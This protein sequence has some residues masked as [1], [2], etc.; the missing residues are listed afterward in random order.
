MDT[1]ARFA[2]P[3]F[4]I[5]CQRC[6]EPLSSQQWS[7][8][9]TCGGTLRLDVDLEPARV[10]CR[11]EP[12]GRLNRFAP[13]LPL[14][15]A[16]DTA[17]GDT[18]L[19]VEEF[20][21]VRCAMKL[22]YLNP[23]GSFKD[24][25]A[26]V[27]AARC[28]ELGFD[29]IVVDS[30]GNAGV[31]MALMGL[32]LHVA[33]DVFLPRATPEGKKQLLR[34]LQARLHEVDGDRMQVQ[35]ETLAY[36]AAGAAYAGHWWNPYFAHGVKTMAYEV[37]EEIPCIDYVFAPVGAGTVLL[38]LHAGFSELR[39]AGA[40]ARMPRY[41]AVQA[42]GFSPVVSDL[43]NH[44]D[45]GEV[46]QLADGIAITNPP[47]RREIAA[48]VTASGGFGI[49]VT[50]REIA[51]ALSWLLSRGYVVEPTSAVP[52]AALLQCIRDGRVP[53]GA[54]V[55][56]PLTGTGLKVLD[57]LAHVTGGATNS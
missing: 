9:H 6:G 45:Q 40:I 51:S 33:V 28:A 18:P 57:K 30:S 7:W 29:S 21:S 49:V 10:T 27:T 42:T 14:Q 5:V 47:R 55:L 12:L 1:A 36:A 20:H 53:R 39:S 23:G 13:V 16:P 11:I 54:T 15:H 41:V 43:G 34:I 48:A 50:D 32:R 26:Y 8:Q 19:V 37:V 56:L 46:S 22:E 38:G 2:N 17:V 3:S 24:R 25:G 35:R 31:S 44:D 52:V 4:S